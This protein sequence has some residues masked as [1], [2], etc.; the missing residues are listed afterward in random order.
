MAEHSAPVIASAPWS[1]ADSLV[2]RVFV[3]AW[4]QVDE[5]HTDSFE[6]GSY[7]TSSTHQ[8]DLSLYPEGLIEGFHLLALLDYLCNGVS[9]I[10]DDRWTGWN[11]G[12]DRV[13]FVSSVTTR[14]KIRARGS[15]ESITPRGDALQVRYAVTLEVAGREKPAMVAEWLVLWSIADDEEG[16]PVTAE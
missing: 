4:L 13:R 1:E 9:F 16:A 14:D 10:E 6:H 11:Y 3:S 8:M 12:L 5:E 7:L 15:V 2:G